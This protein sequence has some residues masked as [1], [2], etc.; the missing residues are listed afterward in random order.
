VASRGWEGGGGRYLNRS[1]PV[2]QEKE[3]GGW[4]EKTCSFCDS[5][6]FILNCIA[7]VCFDGGAPRTG[8]FLLLLNFCCCTHCFLLY[9]EIDKHHF[10]VPSVIKIFALLM[11]A[12]IDTCCHCYSLLLNIYAELAEVC[13][14]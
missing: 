6:V 7:A 4:V 2:S 5:V 12:C 9:R 1:M 13:L 8:Y 10:S 14:L 3:H 11:F